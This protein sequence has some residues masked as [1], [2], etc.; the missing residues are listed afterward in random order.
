MTRVI[1]FFLWAT[2]RFRL[3]IPRFFPG[4][5]FLPQH[6]NRSRPLQSSRLSIAKSHHEAFLRKTAARKPNRLLGAIVNVARHEP[7]NVAALRT[8]CVRFSR[9]H[10]LDF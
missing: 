8:L 5:F 1:Q 9:E 2:Q 7:P 10:A 4:R 6:L 3:T